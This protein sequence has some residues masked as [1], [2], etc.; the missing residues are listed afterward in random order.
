LGCREKLGSVK[1]SWACLGALTVALTLVGC[2][3]SSSENDSPKKAPPQSQGDWLRS[4]P[5]EDGSTIRFESPGV[6]ADGVT[7]PKY[8]CG[9]GSLWIPLE[10]G[11]VPRGT[12]ELAIYLGRFS[13]TVDGPR[14]LEVPYGSLI[15]TI[16]P[17]VRSI[18]PNTLPPNTGWVGHR[19]FNSCTMK[20]RKGQNILLQ[21][22]ALKRPLRTPFTSP[23]PDWVTKLTEAGLGVDHPLESSRWVTELTEEA[24]ASSRFTATYGS[25]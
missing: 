9:H 25:R 24:L 10:W 18:A 14:Q 22:F 20:K 16:D 5:S 12:K 13:G 1:S 7:P 21:L 6:P 2:G 8:P 4:T 17:S 11:P 23:G 19:P 15:T 3:Q